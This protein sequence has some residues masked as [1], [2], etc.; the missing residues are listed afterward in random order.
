[1]DEKD[2]GASADE[3]RERAKRAQDRLDAA[4][5]SKDQ[6]G[7]GAAAQ[8]AAFFSDLVNSLNA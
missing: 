5:N 2:K 4:R 7:Q 1:M 6:K 3:L 8:G